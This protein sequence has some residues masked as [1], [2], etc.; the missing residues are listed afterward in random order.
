MQNTGE[1]ELLKDNATYLVNPPKGIL[2]A[3]ESA[4]SCCK[5]F[6]D[7]RLECNEES[8]RAF[9][10]MIITAPGLEDLLSGIILTDETIRQSTKNGKLFTN[11]LIEKG[12]KPGIKVDEGI[13]G[14]KSADDIE[15]V[16]QG[17]DGLPLRMAE[18]KKMGASFAK[19]RAVYSVTHGLPTAEALAESVKRMCEYAL[20]CQAV[21]IVPIVE[22][23]VLMDGSH[24]NADTEETLRMVITA[25]MTELKT[26]DVYMP[27]LILKTSMAVSGKNAD[28]RAP[29]E[30]VAE[31]T[32]AILKETVPE[33]IGGVVFLSG[34]QSHEEANANYDAI[35]RL[36]DKLPFKMTYS[37]SRAFQNEALAHYAKDTNDVEGAQKIL[38]DS[39]RDIANP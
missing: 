13:V 3:D 27:G 23:E 26:A 6:D 8:R 32:V 4:K 7:V 35:M 17:I 38:V 20:I 31:R 30:E 14:F 29:A 39:I 11:A 36:S 10:E 24:S 16:T 22:P 28:R 9:R 1:N 19:W 12:I 18:Y 37:F 2:A 21:G 33:D 25:L 15:F 34:G 5:R